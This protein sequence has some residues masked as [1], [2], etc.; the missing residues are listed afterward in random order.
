M[1][2]IGARSMLRVAGRIPGSDSPS[3]G[4]T[5]SYHYVTNTKRLQA[6]THRC[7]HCFAE[8][9]PLPSDQAWVGWREAWSRNASPTR[10]VCTTSPMTKLGSVRSGVDRPRAYARVCALATERALLRPTRFG[11]CMTRCA[12]T[13]ARDSVVTCRQRRDD[14]RRRR[15]LARNPP[16]GWLAGQ[17]QNLRPDQQ[18]YSLCRGPS[19]ATASRFSVL[20][21][22]QHDR[23]RLGRAL[24]VAG[25]SRVGR[26]HERPEPVVLLGGRSPRRYPRGRPTDQHACPGIALKVEPPSGPPVRAA[27]EPI[28]TGSAPSR[29]YVSAAVRHLLTL[30]VVVRRSTGI[31]ATRPR[32]RPP[33][34]R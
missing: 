3:G 14:P 18:P 25:V 22:Q 23:N 20:G 33:L 12:R 6:M 8:G 30:P 15:P 13:G 10:G 32:R 9:G 31:P 2:A 11:G 5:H 1:S 34:A 21:C 27:E 19:S 28:T 24:L 16:S 7:D 17:Q 26:R 4:K 29:K